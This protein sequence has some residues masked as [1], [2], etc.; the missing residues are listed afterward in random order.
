MKKLPLS[1]LRRLVP[2]V[3]VAVLISAPASAQKR[4]VTID[5]VLHL[6][7]VGAPAV[8]PDGTSVLYTIRQWEPAS[9]REKDKMEART[10]IW[11]VPVAGGAPQQI[12]FGE[13]GDTQPQ[14]SPDGQYISFVSARGAGAGEDAPKPQIHL[15][16]ANGGE[17]WKLS[18]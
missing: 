7:A 11:K 3:A 6:K 13:R 15:M 18:D 8:S 9:E 16:R 5:D 2:A 1:M 12:T 10:R 14:W 17:S 4:P